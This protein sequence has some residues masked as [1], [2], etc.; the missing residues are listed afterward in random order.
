[1]RM[2]NRFIWLSVL[3]A[4]GIVMAPMA[5]VVAQEKDEVP[6]RA[7]WRPQAP[8]R[9]E[10][11]PGVKPQDEQFKVDR[12]KIN[13]P[14]NESE[15]E[16]DVDPGAQSPASTEVRPQNERE[17]GVESATAEPAADSLPAREE[18]SAD[19]RVESAEDPPEMET[20]RETRAERT[21]PAPASIVQPEYPRDALRRGLEGYVELEFTVTA[22]GEVTNVAITD[23]EPAGVFEQP[24]RE[25]IRRWRFE[26][27]TA[28][29][30]PVE[31]RV[32]HQFEFNLDG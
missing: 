11:P 32:R 13:L 18:P 9:P 24:V 28:G 5:T 22:N 15:L 2:K 6:A 19:T 27:A 1:M 16:S 31:Q 21:L 29:G 12:P 25:A 30:E 23:S 20:A 7:T 4:V 10:L 8:E 14:G 3:I 26:P 17:R